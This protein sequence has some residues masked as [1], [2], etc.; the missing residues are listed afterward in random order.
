[1]LSILTNQWLILT[2]SILVIFESH[3]TLTQLTSMLQRRKF[4]ELSSLGL[5]AI[6]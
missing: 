3:Y 5:S 4:L 1:M 2:Q 6:T